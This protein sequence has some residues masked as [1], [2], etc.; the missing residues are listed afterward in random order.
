VWSAGVVLFMLLSGDYPFQGNS[1]S[2]LVKTI[3][4]AELRFKDPVWEI[5]SSGAK[6]LV[7]TL[8]TANP[9]ERVTAEE[10]LAHPWLASQ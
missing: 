5:T 8:L 9:A 3:R 1:V 6:H 2:E 7:Q 10:A 4:Q